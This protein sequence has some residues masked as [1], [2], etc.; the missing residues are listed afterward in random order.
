MLSRWSP[1]GQWITFVGRDMQAH[2]MRPDGSDARRVTDVDGWAMYP[3]WSPEG[4]RLAFSLLPLERNVEKR[5]ASAELYTIRLD[6]TD[7]VRLTDNES[8][9]GH[10]YWW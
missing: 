2:V 9:D 5:I 4:A 3:V 10:A 6:G 1:D 8:M 7:L